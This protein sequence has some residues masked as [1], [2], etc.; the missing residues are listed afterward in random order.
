MSKKN[1]TEALK[2][3]LDEKTKKGLSMK[4][5]LLGVPPSTL[6][7]MVII[8]KLAEKKEVPA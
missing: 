2:V 6:A 5:K 3:R 1:Y 8:E 4:A 7:R